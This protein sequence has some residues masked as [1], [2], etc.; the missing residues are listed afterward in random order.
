MTLAAILTIPEDPLKATLDPGIF[1]EPRDRRLAYEDD[2][3]A[4]FV[5]LMRRTA[6]A[7]RVVAIPNAGRRTR[8]EA[9]KRLKEGMAR[10]EPD[11]AVTWADAPTARIEFKNGRD[12][13]D[14]D[15]VEVLNWYHMRGH[16]VAVC[17]TAE[18]A[19]AWLRSIGAPV[20][21]VAR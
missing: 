3:Q 18:G 16:P 10:G 21:G 17:R 11:I 15:Q 20:P 8:W 7:C 14:T 2:R 12:M 4:E 19:M 9:G 13:P 6:R 5:A 1:V